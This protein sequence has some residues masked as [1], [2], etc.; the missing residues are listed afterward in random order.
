MSLH[1]RQALKTVCS[2]TFADKC[3]QNLR[4]YG[5]EDLL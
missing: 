3:I 1:Q 5:M 4:E 2:G